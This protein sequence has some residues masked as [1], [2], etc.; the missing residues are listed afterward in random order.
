M[1]KYYFLQ[2]GKQH[3]PVS[4]SELNNL[5]ASG[6]LALDAQVWIEGAAKRVL[7]K[8]IQGLFVGEAGPV[9]PPPRINTTS[10]PADLMFSQY[11][12]RYFADTRGPWAYGVCLG[13]IA[14][15]TLSLL[16]PV[17]GFKGLAIALVVVIL[18]SLSLLAIYSLQRAVAYL[19]QR[20]RT[21]PDEAQSRTA[22]LG[23]TGLLLC[24]MITPL[25]AAEFFTPR[26]G[27]VAT[28]MPQLQEPQ[29]YLTR[30][31]KSVPCTIY[32]DD[33]LQDTDNAL[34]PTPAPS[35]ISTEPLGE[36]DQ[37]PTV[38][39]E[40]DTP[41]NISDDTEDT[42]QNIP[43][44]TQAPASIPDPESRSI[45]HLTEDKQTPTVNLPNKA[46]ADNQPF[47]VRHPL[48]KDYVDI[49]PIQSQN[50][51]QIIDR[52]VQ[53]ERARSKLTLADENDPRQEEY[54]YLLRYAPH[55]LSGEVS[56]ATYVAGIDKDHILLDLPSTARYIDNRPVV[57]EVV[58][59]MQG[60]DT[61]QIVKIATLSNRP[62]TGELR[63][64]GRFTRGSR[65]RVAGRAVRGYAYNGYITIVVAPTSI[66]PLDDVFH[67]THTLDRKNLVNTAMALTQMAY[68]VWLV[69]QEGNELRAQPLADLMTQELRNMTGR[70]IAWLGR[71]R[72]IT[73]KRILLEDRAIEGD[74]LFKDLG[75]DFIGC[76]MRV[77]FGETR[78]VSEGRSL[79]VDLISPTK[80]RS[81]S[82]G[83]TVRLVGR[84]R[85]V[86]LGSHEVII[87]ITVTDLEKTSEDDFGDLN[88]YAELN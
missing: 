62:K 65:V 51:G 5:A 38:A 73:T 37:I 1:R 36:E 13:L 78:D 29:A 42:P 14:I 30:F 39:S 26:C 44:V 28:L 11:W 75:D 61:D 40:E 34:I 63:G 64:R 9:E 86:D 7:A 41:P 85:A 71:I 35:L 77:F 70:Q 68:E 53:V 66:T 55:E 23:F 58:D 82:T 45:E 67:P 3:G 88:R 47:P 19:R 50:W 74:Q 17:I 18:Q 84:I 69:R 15:P 31:D 6:Q 79:P 76:R 43:G 87:R 54:L 12:A 25:V 16:K 81:L 60:S 57:I 21:V 27:L 72:S 2:A 80:A 83:D 20:Q 56:F 48:R 32:P 52:M 46:T 4:G 10:P 24:I 8:D 33:A 59:T 22:A 49:A